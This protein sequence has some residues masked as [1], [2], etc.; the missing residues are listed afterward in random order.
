VRVEGELLF[1][2]KAVPPNGAKGPHELRLFL[3]PTL[4]T[5]VRRRLR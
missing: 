3:T 4:K 2:D 5:I 1:T